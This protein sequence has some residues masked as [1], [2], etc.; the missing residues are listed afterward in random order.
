MN[1]APVGGATI[2]PRAPLTVRHS[3]VPVSYSSENNNLIIMLPWVAWLECISECGPK[4]YLS[5]VSV[6]RIYIMV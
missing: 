6:Y 4:E 5:E 2:R 1:M 3:R